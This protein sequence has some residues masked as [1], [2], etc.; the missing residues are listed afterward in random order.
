MPLEARQLVFYVVD[1][2]LWAWGYVQK[3]IG[4]MG[5]RCFVWKTASKQMETRELVCKMTMD[6]A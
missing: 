6:A 2:G 3:F 5:T 4:Q 1:T